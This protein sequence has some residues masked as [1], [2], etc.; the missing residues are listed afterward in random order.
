MKKVLALLVLA[1]MLF[2]AVSVYAAQDLPFEKKDRF[3]LLDLG[4]DNNV[5]TMK[6]S[7]GELIIHIGSNTPIVFEDGKSV[8]EALVPGQTLSELLNGRQLIVEYAV[9]TFSL[10][11]QTSPLKVTLLYET[12]MPLPDLVPER[13]DGPLDITAMFN[14]QIVVNGEIIQAPMPYVNGPDGV[15]MVPLRAIAEKLGYTVTW[16]QEERSVRIGAATYIWI[17]KDYYVIGRA[18]PIEFGPA[19]EL[20]N[21][22]T[23]VPM[24]FFRQ[25]LQ[26]YNAYV[27]E[28][29]IVIDNADTS[30]MS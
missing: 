20:T 10:P 18:A 14:G 3:S 26:G 13:G 15:I 5:I 12:I 21:D 6:S 8:R 23:F 30:D 25:V 27:F 19:P 2:S 11:P 9:Q 16:I 7:D 22:R 29:Q 28:G 24:T 4:T 1:V 17:G